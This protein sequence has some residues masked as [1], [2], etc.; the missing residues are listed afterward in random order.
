MSDRPLHRLLLRQLERIGVHDP[1]V[2]PTDP[3]AWK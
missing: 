3:A 2:P 1:S